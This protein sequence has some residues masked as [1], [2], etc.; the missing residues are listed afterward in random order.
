MG[1]AFYGGLYCDTRG[2]PVLSVAVC[3]RCSR[4][5]PYSMLRSDPNAPGLKVCPD[6]V[7]QFD[8]WRLAARQTE[9]I[10]LRHPRPDTSVAIQG[11]GKPIPN[12]PNIATLNEGPNMIGTGFGAA[13]TPAEYGNET[14]EPTP[15]D[16]KKT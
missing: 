4:K 13:F 3:D 1:N 10:T 16:I 8:P 2:Q 14:P 12:A 11:K 15:G 6:D 5:L 7:D 9:N